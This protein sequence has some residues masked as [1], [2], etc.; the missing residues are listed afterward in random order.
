MWGPHHHLPG[1]PDRQSH[2]PPY[3]GIGSFQ[4]RFWERLVRNATCEQIQSLFLSFII[5]NTSVDP[6]LNKKDYLLYTCFS[7]ENAW[8]DLIR[9]SSRK[10]YNFTNIFNTSENFSFYIKISLCLEILMKTQRNTPDKLMA[11]EWWL[12][13]HVMDLK[14]RLGSC[15]LFSSFNPGLSKIQHCLSPCLLNV[16]T[17]G[18]TFLCPH[19]STFAQSFS[20]F[21][22][23]NCRPTPGFLR[24]KTQLLSAEKCHQIVQ[25]Y[26]CGRLKM[27][28]SRYG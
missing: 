26:L 1:L 5:S 6:Y 19:L 16:A 13:S 14:Q 3:D 27:L 4:I 15:L 7:M 22:T 17:F 24:R 10:S 23:V 9:G 8:T 2:W 25:T 21:V 20:Y 28:S 18:S 12:L 11:G